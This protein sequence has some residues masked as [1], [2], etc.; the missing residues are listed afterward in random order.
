MIIEDEKLIEKI[1]ELQKLE[2]EIDI[3]LRKHKHIVKNC[4]E[5]PIINK[6][7]G[8]SL[9]SKVGQLIALGKKL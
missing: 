9:G 2:A 7:N 4:C 6:E 1:L 5:Y 3:V 8:L